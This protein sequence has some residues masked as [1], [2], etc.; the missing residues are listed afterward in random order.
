M[1]LQRSQIMLESWQHQFLRQEAARQGTTISALV[2]DWLT[3]FIENRR[4]VVLDDD[5]GWEL[6]GM[7]QGDPPHDGSANHDKYIYNL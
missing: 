4:R 3:E 7:F 2:R 6:I 1:P 5:P